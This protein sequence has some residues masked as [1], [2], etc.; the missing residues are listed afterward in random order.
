MPD[1]F[2]IPKIGKSAHKKH[3]G[4]MK[5]SKNLIAVVG[6]VIV[7]CLVI[8][9]FAY[10]YIAPF[11]AKI[12]YIFSADSDK[13]KVSKIAGVE[14]S[15]N[16]DN[17]AKNTLTIPQQAIRQNIVTF[18]LKL[19]S[20]KIDGVW[21]NLRFKGN[22]KELK[23]G[24]KG[25]EDDLYA[26]KPL[27]NRD[28]EQL[29]NIARSGQILFWQKEKKYKDI[30]DFLNN[31]PEDKKIGSY[32]VDQGDLLK[33]YTNSNNDEKGQVFFNNSLRGTHTAYIKVNNSPLSITI[34][35]RDLN[36][37]K[38]ADPLGIDIY[39]GEK[40]IYETVIPDDG[41]EDAN[42]LKFVP[43][44]KEIQIKDINSGIYKI[45]LIDKS[46]TGDISIKSIK[47]NQAKIVFASPIFVIDEEPTSL[48]STSKQINFQTWHNEGLQIIKLDK[49]NSLEIKDRSKD[50]IYNF[51]K[52][53]I[54]SSSTSNVHLIEIPKNDLIISGDGYFSFDKNSLFNP[55]PFK[56]TNLSNIYNL[57]DIDYI[58][59]NYQ[60]VKVDGN[61]KTAQAYFDPKDI[62]IKG[63]KLYFSLDSPGLTGITGEYMIDS[64]EV[65]VDKPGWFDSTKQNSSVEQSNEKNSGNNNS[66]VRSITQPI[67]ETWDKVVNFFKGLWPFGG[68]EQKDEKDRTA[69]PTSE[70]TDEPEP[71][72]IEKVKIKFEVLNG[73]AEPGT[74]G[75]FADILKNND[76]TDVT[77]GNI[78]TKIYTDATIKYKEDK[79]LQDE[80]EEYIQKLTALLKKESYKV[81][82]DQTATRSS[83]I[84]VI[85]GVKQSSTPKPIL[86]ITP[87]ISSSPSATPKPN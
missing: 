36:A 82:Q 33:L 16:I 81:T 15:K 54:T 10:Q 86:S 24:V 65:T 57:N 41:N 12:T 35:K 78:G 9:F 73:G 21:V 31:I 23:I 53:N 6:L 40:K 70:P 32:F 45:D 51:K 13:D 29:K 42:N 17:N 34:E 67:T 66:F 3:L 74:A 14:D 69:E 55:A 56:A 52:D 61:L 19:L 58:F 2:D 50:Y 28:L 8:Y 72:E 64:L 84:T 44:N 25:Y 7:F 83:I 80:Q 77:T 20:E 75:K 71:T 30:I 85:L 38:G 22:P 18:N 5:I 39:K 59:A 4:Q 76:F 26:Y 37:Y 11:G 1:L 63:N 48:W 27:F 60:K 46:D 47:T 68:D 43:Q 79:N 62:K 87:T 49:L